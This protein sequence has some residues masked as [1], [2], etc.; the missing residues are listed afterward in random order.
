MKSALVV[1]LLSFLASPAMGGVAMR[2][3]G[4]HSCGMFL[5]NT[6]GGQKE[7]YKRLY[8]AWVWG[9]MSG[10]NW[11]SEQRQSNPPDEATV[12]A[13]VSNF[14]RRNPLL[15]VTSAATVLVADTG[16]LPVEFKYEK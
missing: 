4:T 5:Q 2:G 15:S 13:F 3:M 7:E 1:L 9:F 14:C 11:V 10:H 16:G 6:E 12:V 8:A